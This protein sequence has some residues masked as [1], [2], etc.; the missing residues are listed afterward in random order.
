MWSCALL[1]KFDIQ[2]AFR[3]LPIAPESFN[4]LGFCF[5]GSF[6]YDMCLPMGCSLSCHYFK[7]FVTILQWVLEYES[8]C[9]NTIHYFDDFLFIGLLDSPICSA[10]LWLFLLITTFF[11]IPIVLEKTVFPS[12][13][14]EFLGISFDTLLFQYQLPMLKI[15]KLQS[16]IVFFLRRK[17][18]LL[19][20]LHSFLGLLAFGSRIMLEGRIFSRRMSLATSTF[21][22]PFSYICLTSDI[23]DDL[24]VWSQFPADYNDR[25]ILQEDFVF[26]AD[27]ELYT[28]AAGSFSFSAIWRTHWS[29]GFWVS[30]KATKNIV[31]LELFPIVVAFEIWGDFFANKRIIIQITREFFLL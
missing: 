3:L 27:M 30:N 22:P 16:L 2:S 29:C 19:K 4:S 25:S 13:I 5:E 10:L 11:G 20:E 31:L 23:K 7:I 26:S 15:S 8:G 24:L 1:A 17:K 12:P 6:F 28:D 9:D 14:I 21:K 18:V